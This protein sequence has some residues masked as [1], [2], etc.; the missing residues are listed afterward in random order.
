MT[1]KNTNNEYQYCYNDGL[2]KGWK[3]Y[4][5]AQLDVEP[6]NRPVRDTLKVKLDMGA[7]ANILPVRTYSNMFLERILADGTPD[8]EHLQSTNIEF[9][10]NKEGIIRS[11]G[12]INLD[13]ALPGKKF[14][15]AQFFLSNH[16]NQFLI[17]HPSC[18]RLR[19]YT[20]HMKNSAP[21][22][23]QN[24]LLPQL[25]EVNQTSPDEGPIRVE[26]LQRRYPDLF[27]VIGKFEGEYHMV[28]DP[29]VPPSQHAMRKIPIE[30]QEKI[31]KK[32][33]Q[34][35]EQ[36]IITKVTEPTEW[37]NSINLSS[38]TKWRPAHMS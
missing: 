16:Y 20:L 29:N 9:E 11:L 31:E 26:D 13:I 18:D 34:M 12:C 3:T 24:K 2:S 38:E 32:L 33:D 5:L 17:G 6:T 19:A 8:P 23:D 35:E 21:K 28:T 22:F 15:T 25:S 10:C 7:E 14:I 36:G 37:V 4:V 1:C 30:Y 27:D